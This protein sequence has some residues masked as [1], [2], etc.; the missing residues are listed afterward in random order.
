MLN[1]ETPHRSR[2][3]GELD[4]FFYEPEHITYSDIVSFF[5]R[6]FLIIAG[7]AAIAGT[8]GALYVL[9]ST[10]LYSARVELLIDPSAT[11]LV[12]DDRT[13]LLIDTAHMESQIALIA[14]AA[15]LSAAVQRLNLQDDPDFTSGRPSERRKLQDLLFGAPPAD[16]R[17]Q[18]AS[19]ALDPAMRMRLAVD[20]LRDSIDVRRGGASYVIAI[21][22]TTSTAEKS[23]NVANAVAQSYLQEQIDG[24]TASARA[25][26][27]WLE[28]RIR[29]LRS[30]LDESARQ[31]Q[32]MKSGRNY[33][34]T[35][36]PGAQ[37]S[38]MTVEAMEAT[39]ESY[40]KLYETYLVSL[41]KAIEQESFIFSNARIITPAIPALV[42]SFPRSKLIIAFSLFAGLLFG[43]AA[44]YLRQ[45]MDSSVRTPKQVQNYI[46]LECL[47]R[48]PKVV[49][50]VSISRKSPFVS[51]HKPAS[52]RRAMF[53]YVTEAP[54]SQFSGAVT[55]LKTAIV[56]SGRQD[57]V[58]SLGIT[59]ALPGEGKSTLSAN[60]ATA[61]AL[62]SYKTL[63]IDA[64]V[65]NSVISETFAPDAKKGLFEV[66]KGEAEPQD[67]IV[68]GKGAAPDVL[69]VVSDKNAPISYSWLSS[70]NMVAL[71]KYLKDQYH[72]VVVDLPPL[73]PVAEGLTISG[74]LD[75]VILAVEWGKTPRD[76]LADVTYGL[77]L[78][79][80]NIL[81][82][83]L[84]KVDEGAV[85]LRLKKAWKYY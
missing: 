44:A 41:T 19:P 16:P 11:Q 29:S 31:L 79:D 45:V 28:D 17:Q 54:F 55:A 52:D 15:I 35:N 73:A 56:K 8:L 70:D 65:H 60:L 40:R 2:A 82:I 25:S 42:K 13:E 12:R 71:L 33:P 9:T 47:A 85:H 49:R 26:S 74:L 10:P 51:V 59:S 64:D 48:I 63:I 3:R 34:V 80:A 53:Q 46:G 32:L 81:G 1:R 38:A 66:L 39:V 14:S 37:D 69:P 27:A 78:A 62:S 77:N 67:C 21:A 6:Y 50:S 75:S 36:Q 7:S 30:K 58:R 24:K 43:I 72:L 83:V 84:T 18:Q 5:R 22:V 20:A 76:L 23:A 4:Q 57:G 61:F 68:A